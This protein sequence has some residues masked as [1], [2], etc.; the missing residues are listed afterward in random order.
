MPLIF[1]REKFYKFSPLQSINQSVV[2]AINALTIRASCGA[3]SPA[4]PPLSL[5]SPSSSPFP[6]RF[7][8]GFISL[9][10]SGSLSFSTPSLAPFSGYS[11][12]SLFLSTSF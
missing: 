7:G 10:N 2:R 5:P 9:S 6:L 4:R 3:S 1:K 11:P 12:G 8:F